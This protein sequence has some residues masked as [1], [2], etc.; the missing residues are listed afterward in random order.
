ML[1]VN[2]ASMI[3]MGFLLLIVDGCLYRDPGVT[4]SGGYIVSAISAGSPCRLYLQHAPDIDWT[5]TRLGED[6]VLSNPRRRI[7]ENV[8]S[9]GELL[10]KYP[11]QEIDLADVA[12]VIENVT[13]YVFN[14]TYIAGKSAESYFLLE[15]SAHSCEYFSTI[16]EW[17]NQVVSAGMSPDLLSDPKGWLNQDRHPA[18]CPIYAALLLLSAIIPYGKRHIIDA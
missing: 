17:R 7:V 6:I 18:T 2:V 13:S 4:L 14:D 10:Q 12:P 11:H 3:V 1:K 16:S 8:R 5:A 15:V 9:V